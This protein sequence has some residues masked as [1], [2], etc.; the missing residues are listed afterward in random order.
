MKVIMVEKLTPVGWAC[1]WLCRD[2]GRRLWWD[3]G[4]VGFSFA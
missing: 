4:R 2:F 1:K 3:A